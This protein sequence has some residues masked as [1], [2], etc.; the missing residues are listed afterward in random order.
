MSF[1]QCSVCGQT[2]PIEQF[3][4]RR[5]GGAYTSRCK[6]CDAARQTQWRAKHRSYNAEYYAQNRDSEARR[7]AQYYFGQRSV[8]LPKL[9]ERASLRRATV[10]QATPPWVDHSALASF[11]IEAD[12]MT[13]ETGVPHEVDHIIPLQGREVRGLHVPWNM[14]VIPRSENR[15]KSNKVTTT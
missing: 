13:R 12:R 10:L 15:S 7:F 5:A 6:P 14:Q 1:K 9:R 11:Y 3:R 4:K 2:K 8:L